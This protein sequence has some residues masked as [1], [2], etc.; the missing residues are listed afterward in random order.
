MRATICRLPP[1]ISDGS[2]YYVVSCPT[3]DDAGPGS[4]A[5]LP[6]SIG[7]LV[8]GCTGSTAA[9]ALTAEFLA[10]AINEKLDREFINGGG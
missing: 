7:L 2:E 4:K 1:K 8:G 3:I 6:Q 9:T 10:A 5:A